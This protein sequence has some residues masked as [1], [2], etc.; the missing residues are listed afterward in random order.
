MNASNKESIE[1]LLVEAHSDDSNVSRDDVR[2][3]VV[4][5]KDRGN[6]RAVQIGIASM[7]GVVALLLAWSLILNSEVSRVRALV[8]K[9]PSKS[10]H[11]FSEMTMEWCG[12]EPADFFV[13]RLTARKTANV[14]ASSLVVK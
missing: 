10:V 12:E 1:S 13:R 2:S 5:E 4:R 11:D 8:N 14:I 7:V 3:W 6:R 9:S